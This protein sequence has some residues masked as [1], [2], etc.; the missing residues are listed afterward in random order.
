M[1]IIWHS[2]LSSSHIPYSTRAKIW[3]SKF[4][5]Q[6]IY[7]ENVNAVVKETLRDKRELQ[8]GFTSA[9]V[10]PFFENPVISMPFEIYLLLKRGTQIGTPL[11]SEHH[12]FLGGCL[13]ACDLTL[14]TELCQLWKVAEKILS[15]YDKKAYHPSF[16]SLMW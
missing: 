6:Q 16:V 11:L 12:C 14:E 7:V 8:A 9:V 3:A 10:L 1:C 4:S 5:H 13:Y 2:P 15:Y